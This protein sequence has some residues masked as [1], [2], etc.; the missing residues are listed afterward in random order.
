[1]DLEV[2]RLQRLGYVVEEIPPNLPVLLQPPSVQIEL[3][4]A[5]DRRLIQQVFRQP[6]PVMADKDG[7]VFPGLAQQIGRCARGQ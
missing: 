3:E 2:V 6:A 1:M 7:S 5:R 4:R